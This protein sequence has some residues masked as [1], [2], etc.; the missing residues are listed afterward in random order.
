MIYHPPKRA[1]YIVFVDYVDGRQTFDEFFDEAAAWDR[2]KQAK[3]EKITNARLAYECGDVF[4]V[5]EDSDGDDTLG[6][7]REQMIDAGRGHLLRDDD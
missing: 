1:R 4:E 2:Y 7:Y 5:W 3:T 6:T